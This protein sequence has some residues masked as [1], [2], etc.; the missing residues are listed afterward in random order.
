MQ[1]LADQF[2]KQKDKEL[3]DRE[4]A[5]EL[6]EKGYDAVGGFKEWKTVK[7]VFFECQ[8]FI[9]IFQ[10]NNIKPFEVIDGT[11]TA[12]EYG[13]GKKAYDKPFLPGAV[14]ESIPETE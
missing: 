9:S 10:E 13:R 11:S 14:D 12:L 3:C 2:D 8:L 7:N 4:Y 6:A 5:L 1:F